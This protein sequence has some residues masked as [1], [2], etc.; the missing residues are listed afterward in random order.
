MLRR[1]F[2]SQIKA[3]LLSFAYISFIS[4]CTSNHL[5]VYTD[6]L[7]NETLA[8][9]VVETP[10]PCL[11]HPN[12]GQRVIIIWTL[13]K[14]HLSYQDLHLKIFIRFRNKK[15]I[16]LLHPIRH[17]KGTYVYTLLNQEYIDNGGILTYKVELMGNDNII[18]EWRHQ[19]WTNLILIGQ[20][21]PSCNQKT[22]NIDS[23]T[24]NEFDVDDINI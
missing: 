7:S 4:S 22:E 16:V 24:Q 9:Y 23:E 12:I 19:M 13:K 20:N 8:S 1:L 15:E 11:N 6:Y 10:D 21:N 14:C 18:E 2:F 5:A 3:I 17:A